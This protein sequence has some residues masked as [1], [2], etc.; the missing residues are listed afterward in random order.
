MKKLSYLFALCLTL[1]FA[2]SKAQSCYADFNYWT[3]NLT[4]NFL[5]S[6]FMSQGNMNYSWSFGDGSNGSSMMNPSHTYV[7]PGTY[8]V[9]LYIWNSFC[10]DTICK[11]VAVSAPPPACSASFV[12]QIGQNGSVSFNSTSNASTTG[13]SLFWT[14]GDGNT[15]FNT[16]NPTNT[17]T[18]SGTYA[19]QLD[20]YDSLT[21]C[22]SSFIDSL[23]INLSNPANC[24]ASYTVA[25]DSSAPFKVI[26]YNT[27]SNASSHSYTWDFGDGTTGSGRTPLHQ[28][29]NFGTYAVCLT[30]TDTLLNC[31]SV[32]CD[33]LGMDSLGNLK[34]AGFG[35]EVRNPIA[36]GLEEEK[37]SVSE[38]SIFPNPASNKISVDLTQIEGIQN[39]RI[40]DISGR[41][42]IDRNNTPSG[43]IESFDVS[44]L[45]NGF[46]FFILD[47]GN[48]QHIEKF[49]ISK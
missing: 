9:C 12:Y 40:M 49:I 31:T 3:N 48:T 29:Q 19:V 38:L 7:N 33:S 47:N 21:N 23:Q 27:S 11:V 42:V 4:A 17:Y 28:Y 30:I 15:A 35:I 1:T 34:S 25:I 43:N 45:D 14:F 13:I 39:I 2:S 10:A 46:Y 18:S 24:S 44:S 32:F 26:I 8:N 20:L 6:S 37:E 22:S 5:D 16:T 41:L 36:V